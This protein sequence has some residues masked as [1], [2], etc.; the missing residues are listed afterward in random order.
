MSN[1]QL[2]S[3]PTSIK[4]LDQL[5]ELYLSWNKLTEL[6]SEICELKKMKRLD[7]RYNPLRSDPIRVLAMT[8]MGSPSPVVTGGFGDNFQSNCNQ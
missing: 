6:S 2:V 8:R 5:K 3:L 1:N 7:V 4:E